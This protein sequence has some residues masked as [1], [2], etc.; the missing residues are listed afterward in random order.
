M[1]RAERDGV[2]SRNVASLVKLQRNNNAK[3]LKEVERLQKELDR[4]A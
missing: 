3:L 1:W 4:E 2:V